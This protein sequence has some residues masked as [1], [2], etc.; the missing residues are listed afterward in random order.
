MGV[1]NL[2]ALLEPCGR[3]IDVQ[4]LRGKRVAVGEYKQRAPIINN[5]NNIL[6]DIILIFRRKIY[7]RC[8]GMDIQ[9]HQSYAR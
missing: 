5:Y 9:I 2:W 4:A 7:C 8:L 6:G 1:T 3:R